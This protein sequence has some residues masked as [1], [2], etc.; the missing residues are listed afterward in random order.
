MTRYRK[1]KKKTRCVLGSTQSSD[2][3]GHTGWSPSIA[4]R[5][6][7]KERQGQSLSPMMVDATT[8]VG[9]WWDVVQ[10]TSLVH[11]NVRCS[12]WGCQWCHTL[13]WVHR[14]YKRHTSDRDQC[15]NFAPTHVSIATVQTITELK[16]HAAIAVDAAAAVD[17]G[18]SVSV[19]ALAM[20]L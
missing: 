7:R 2:L 10:W 15:R 14:L 9:L 19:C 13:T 12:L 16:I 11:L 1:F 17:V 4:T 8:D 6:S 5:G 18:A 20:W 3:T